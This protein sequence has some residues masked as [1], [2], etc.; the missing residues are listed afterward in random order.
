MNPPDFDLSPFLQDPKASLTEWL[1]RYDETSPAGSLSDLAT[2]LKWILEGELYSGGPDRVREMHRAAE[3]IRAV[4]LREAPRS[5]LDRLS[6]RAYPFELEALRILARR[7]P[8]WG[9]AWIQVMLEAQPG[10]VQMVRDL[11]REGEISRP[12]G[13]TY[14]IA[15]IG[16][17][18]LRG[19]AEALALAEPSLL[20]GELL[21]FFQ[22]EGA[23]EHSFAARDKYAAPAHTWSR[24]ILDWIASGDLSREATRDAILKT[25]SGDLP[26]FQAGWFVRLLK[27]LKPNREDFQAAPEVW[28][29]LAL[30]DQGPTQALAWMAYRGLEKAK[31][32]PPERVRA[33]LEGLARGAT[34]G[35]AKDALKALDRWVQRSPDQAL[36]AAQ[37]AL[38]AMVWEDREIQAGVLARLS[39]WARG[40][41][42][43]E[44]SLWARFQDLCLP[45]LRLELESKGRANAPDRDHPDSDPPPEF[46]ELSAPKVPDPRPGKVPPLESPAQFLQLL[47]LEIERPEDPARL[48]RLIDL[49]SAWVPEL[50]GHPVLH[51][52]A[53]RAR[54]KTQAQGTWPDPIGE[55]LS[56]WLGALTGSLASSLEL[57]P[58]PGPEDRPPRVFDLLRQLLA[59]RVRCPK[60]GPRLS[61]PDREGFLVSLE[62]LQERLGAWTQAPELACPTDWLLALARLDLSDCED[63]PSRRAKV[64]AG[65]E[66][67]NLEGFFEGLCARAKGAASL[68]SLAVVLGPEPPR[69]FRCLEKTWQ[70]ADATYR[71][72]LLLRDLPSQPSLDPFDA[73]L[74]QRPW[75]QQDG[76]AGT[77]LG[78]VRWAATV[79]PRLRDGFYAEGA[80]RLDLDWSEVQWEVVG[81][82]ESLELEPRRLG[83][84]GRM[85]LGKALAAKE[86][87][88]VTQAREEWARRARVGRLDPQAQ[89]QDAAWLWDQGVI[90]PQRFAKNLRPLLLGEPA[91]VRSLEE[92][93]RGLLTQIQTTGRAGLAGVLELWGECLSSLGKTAGAIEASPLAGLCGKGKARRIFR[94]L[95]R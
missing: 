41:T 44:A 61:S 20:S 31:A 10:K 12:T 38:E 69:L 1:E 95:P 75:S 23:G 87:G 43:E 54:A 80:M 74:S 56:A 18:D 28:L 30:K 26:Q 71:E 45:S 25:L 51:S 53:K 49:P 60:P 86:P 90:L 94:A 84:G 3:R 7:K 4:L 27:E 34:K 19:G 32:L 8:E 73:P 37:V 16:A 78:Q 17:M 35:R 70:A 13:T 11:V 66:L 82:L 91:E 81:Y 83:P 68:L 79:S 24:R 92:F 67:S 5:L 9:D 40:N 57:A 2:A 29:S 76:I 46:S 72:V 59:E 55:L 15:S 36:A 47:S 93:L 88:Q 42:P 64:E 77:S 33:A 6:W 85:L 58:I 21:E 52:L 22:V 63:P 62:A 14:A 89:A 48:E 39:D 65:L 50:R